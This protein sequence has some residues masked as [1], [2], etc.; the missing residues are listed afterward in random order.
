M[1]LAR[2]ITPALTTVR[3]PQIEMG[4]AAAQFLLAKI[5]EETDLSS[6]TFETEFIERGSLKPPRVT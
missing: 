6:T 2:V 1:G 4:R 5:G 3:V